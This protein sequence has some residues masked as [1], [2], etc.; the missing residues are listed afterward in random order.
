[1]SRSPESRW[2]RERLLEYPDV[3]E[4]AVVV[5]REDTPGG[6]RLVAYLVGGQEVGAEML[7][8]H[9]AARLPEYMAPTAFVVLDSLPL[10]PN[11]TVDRRA[12]PAP[13]AGAYA[14]RGTR[15]PVGGWR[16]WSRRSGG[17]CSGWI[18][19]AA[20][21]TSSSWAGTP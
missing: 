5:A 20:T 8:A 12:L 11:G 13:G 21:T 9:L 10:T 17:N 4:A 3:R 15:H 16:P 19:W 7:R 2:S 14:A 6:K 18:G 1:M